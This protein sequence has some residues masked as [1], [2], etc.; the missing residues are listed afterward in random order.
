MT[1]IAWNKRYFNLFAVLRCLAL[2]CVTCWVCLA[3][4]APLIVPL[5]PAHAAQAMP[6]PP[7][8]TAQKP[9]NDAPVIVLSVKKGATIEMSWDMATPRPY[10]WKPRRGYFS[11]P[12]QPSIAVDMCR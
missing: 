6:T 11:K 9:P 8:S 4:W 10:G 1:I 12:K 5:T 7:K 3:F 2:T